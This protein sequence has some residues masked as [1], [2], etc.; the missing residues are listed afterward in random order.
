MES[1]LLSRHKADVLQETAL[2]GEDSGSPLP[3]PQQSAPAN[4]RAAVLVKER[5]QATHRL[6]AD[7]TSGLEGIKLIINCL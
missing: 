6:I 1:A 2:S 5:G 7:A 4:Q 3:K